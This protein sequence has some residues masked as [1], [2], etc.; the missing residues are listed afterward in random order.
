MRFYTEANV[1]GKLT[2]ERFQQLTKKIPLCD[3]IELS[4]TNNKIL[5][6][7]VSEQS[8]E[9]FAKSLREMNQPAVVYEGA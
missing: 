9:S 3:L 8:A 6:L 7:F 4:S 5:A 1:K 2:Q